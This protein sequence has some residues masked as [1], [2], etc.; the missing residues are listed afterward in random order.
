MDAVPTSAPLPSANATAPAAQQQPRTKSKAYQTT[1]AAEADDLKYESKYKELKKKVKEVEEDNEQLYVKILQAQQSI[2]RLRLER[3]LIY[4]RLASL[5]PPSVAPVTSSSN[6]M[7]I[8][9]QEPAASSSQTQTPGR[10]H[11]Q[12]H[13]G[14]N[15]NHHS[16]SSSTPHHPHPLS[17]SF[18]PS[19]SRDPQPNGPSAYSQQPHQSPNLGHPRDRDAYQYSPRQT[20]ERMLPPIK[21]THQTSPYKD[22]GGGNSSSSRVHLPPPPATTQAASSSVRESGERDYAPRRSSPGPVTGATTAPSTS[23]SRR[24]SFHESNA[25]NGSQYPPE[26]KRMQ[27]PSYPF[28]TG[29]N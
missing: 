17:Q 27:F 21:D 29:H 6:A 1:I 12:Q 16:S 23:S 15:A 20:Q 7:Q 24:A 2:Q 10:H 28:P 26:D 8:T 3:A 22:N 13:G 9:D 18:T 14:H 19:S 25:H 5:P 4:E 11:S